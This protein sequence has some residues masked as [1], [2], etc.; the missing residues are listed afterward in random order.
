MTRLSDKHLAIPNEDV[1]WADPGWGQGVMTPPPLNI[2]KC[3]GFCGNTGP[4]PMENYKASKLAFNVG[5]DWPPAKRRF[6]GG[7]MMVRF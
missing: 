6:A 5:H 7:P 1:G 4:D 2:T 3:R